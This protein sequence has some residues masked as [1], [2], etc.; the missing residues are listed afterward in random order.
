VTGFYLVM[1]LRLM[2]LTW[3]PA[4]G[5]LHR[6]KFACMLERLHTDG[7]CRCVIYVVVLEQR[8]DE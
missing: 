5:E 3:A 1:C 7:I 4:S 2:T 6:D 8:G